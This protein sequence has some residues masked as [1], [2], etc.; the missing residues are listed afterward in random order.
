MFNELEEKRF[1]AHFMEIMELVLR[2]GMYFK[3]SMTGCLRCADYDTLTG[4]INLYFKHSPS[5]ILS[6][7]KLEGTLQKTQ[8][9]HLIFHEILNL[10]FELEPFFSLTDISAEEFGEGSFDKGFYFLCSSRYLFKKI[11]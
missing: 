4:H 11:L 10:D 8:V 5:N 7:L 1:I 9:L 6:R 3:G 2:R